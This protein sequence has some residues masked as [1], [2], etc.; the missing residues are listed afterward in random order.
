MLL[1][2]S[3]YTKYNTHTMHIPLVIVIGIVIILGMIVD[4]NAKARVHSEYTRRRWASSQ[5]TA[6]SM[7]NE[8]P[9]GVHYEYYKRRR[10]MLYDRYASVVKLHNDLTTKKHRQKSA[11]NVRHYVRH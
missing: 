2:K 7:F 8:L 9:I 10:Q 3:T 1:Y 11:L 4:A 5:N 6:F